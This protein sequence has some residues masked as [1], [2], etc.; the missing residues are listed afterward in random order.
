MKEKK[1]EKKVIEVVFNEKEYYEIKKNINE[2]D[3]KAFISVYKSINTYG[4]GF[5]EIFIRRS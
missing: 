3:S 1:I 4:E 2:I 5:E